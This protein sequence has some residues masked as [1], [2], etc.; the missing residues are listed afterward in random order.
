MTKKTKSRM[1]KGPPDSSGEL[2]LNEEDPCQ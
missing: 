2:L 1:T